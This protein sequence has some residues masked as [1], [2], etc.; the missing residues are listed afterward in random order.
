[1]DKYYLT[2]NLFIEKGKLYYSINNDKEKIKINDRNMFKYVGEYGWEKLPIQYRRK[3]N[4]NKFLTY[5]TKIMG[6]TDD[7]FGL[8]LARA[9]AKEPS[10]L[11]SPTFCSILFKL[12][13]NL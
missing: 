2:P 13:T 1:M 7:A 5:S 11:P 9:T 12:N 3:L 6:A 10:L 4:D 8:I